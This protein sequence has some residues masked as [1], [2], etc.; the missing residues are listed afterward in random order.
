VGSRVNELTLEQELLLCRIALETRELS[1]EQLHMALLSCWEEKLRQ[2][3]LFLNILKDNDLPAR[4][5]ENFMLQEPECLEDFEEVFG[6][7]P[8]DEEAEG[9]VIAM[10]EAATLE[11]DMDE[12]VADETGS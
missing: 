4:M 6:Y 12:I 7:V 2:K 3:Q 5:D 9:Y 8:S 1:R 10:H 11:L